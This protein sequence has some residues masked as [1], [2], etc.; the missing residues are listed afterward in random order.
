MLQEENGGSKPGAS[1]GDAV[2]GGEGVA[3]VGVME[4]APPDTPEEMGGKEEGNEAYVRVTFNGK[5]VTHHITDCKDV[6]G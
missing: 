2:S 6:D 1:A 5:P 4:S 3:G